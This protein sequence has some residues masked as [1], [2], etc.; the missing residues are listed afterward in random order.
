M[1]GLV[2]A[3][4]YLTAIMDNK[5]FTQYNFR[6]GDKD[7]SSFKVDGQAYLREVEEPEDV[8]QIVLWYYQA[9]ALLR[10]I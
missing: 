1:K 8:R 7:M 10:G 3:D 2:K 4:K 5:G 6:F 9:N